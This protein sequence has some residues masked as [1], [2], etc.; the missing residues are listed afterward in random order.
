MPAISIATLLTTVLVSMSIPSAITGFFRWQLERKIIKRDA[1]REDE[2]KKKDEA[3]KQNE[4]ITIKSIN[5]AIALGEATARAVQRIPDAK[6]NGDMH[7]ALEYATRI[8]HEQKDFLT[9]QGI[10][11]L[12]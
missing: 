10:D 7:A 11:H 3:R 1:K 8:K 6:C 12:Y 2:E 4:L 9:K 5:A